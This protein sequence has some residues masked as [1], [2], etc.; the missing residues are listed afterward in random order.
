[1]REMPATHPSSM[2]SMSEVDVI[3]DESSSCDLMLKS[4]SSAGVVSV[5]SLSLWFLLRML[6]ICSVAFSVTPSV[7][8]EHC[9][10]PRY[11]CASILFITEVYGAS[12]RSSWSIPI[13]L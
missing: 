11:V 7:M 6:V 3:I 12:T 1:M 10:P 8:A 2:V 9:M 13:E 4:S 5:A